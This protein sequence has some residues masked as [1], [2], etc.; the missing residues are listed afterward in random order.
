VSVGNRKMKFESF[1]KNGRQFAGPYRAEHV[2]MFTQAEAWYVL[3]V[4]CGPKAHESIA[5]GITDAKYTQSL[6]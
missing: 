2:L 5:Q 1:E 4:V 3:S 6:G